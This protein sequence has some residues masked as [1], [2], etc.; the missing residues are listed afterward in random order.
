[1]TITILAFALVATQAGGATVRRRIVDFVTG[2][3]L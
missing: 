3:A 1:M 2:A